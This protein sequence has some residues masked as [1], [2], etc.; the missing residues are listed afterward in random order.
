MKNA[1][2]GSYNGSSA[3]VE[4]SPPLARCAGVQEQS[5]GQDV[6]GVAIVAG[7]SLG[8]VGF[9]PRCTHHQGTRMFVAVWQAVDRPEHSKDDGPVLEGHQ[10]R[11]TQGPSKGQHWENKNFTLRVTFPP[12][13]YPWSYTVQAP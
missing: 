2:E 4:H 1:G 8:A 12:L 3:P 13:A 10:G 9:S 5:S 11:K 7:D 6:S